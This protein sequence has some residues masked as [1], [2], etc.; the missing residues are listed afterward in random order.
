MAVRMRISTHTVRVRTSTLS[1]ASLFLGGPRAHFPHSDAK[2]GTT[3]MLVFT[4]PSQR[5][6]LSS[7]I[8]WSFFSHAAQYRRGLSQTKHGALGTCLERVETSV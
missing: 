8:K 7:L 5:S 6:P 1:Q 3:K 4:L 2:F